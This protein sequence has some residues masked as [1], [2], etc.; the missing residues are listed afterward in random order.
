MNKVIFYLSILIL[1]GSCKKDELNVTYT[2]EVTA[3]YNFIHPVNAVGASVYFYDSETDYLLNQN[4]SHTQILD[5][6]GMASITDNSDKKYWIRI[7]LDTLNNLRDGAIYSDTFTTTGFPVNANAGTFYAKRANTCILS[8]T[9]VT[10]QLNV[11]NL[12]AAVNG[13]TVRLYYNLDDYNNDKLPFQNTTTYSQVFYVYGYQYP[14]FTGTTD[15]SG[16]VVFTNLEPRKYWFRVVKG[17]MNNN[18]GTINTTNKLADDPNVTT[19]IDV[20]IN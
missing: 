17:A 15:A 2:T 6:R 11:K 9:P 16:A 20:G 13:A 5:A 18:G 10:L 8:T 3:L 4:P 12:G 7:T 14:T 1:F 19:S